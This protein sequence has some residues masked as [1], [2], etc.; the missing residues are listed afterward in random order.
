LGRPQRFRQSSPKVQQNPARRTGGLA[1]L[2][3]PTRRAPADLLR[4]PSARVDDV[5]T[6]AGHRLVQPSSRIPLLTIG[7]KGPNKRTGSDLLVRAGHTQGR[8]EA[9]PSRSLPSKPASHLHA[10]ANSD[11]SA[12]PWGAT[13]NTLTA[14]GAITKPQLLRQPGTFPNTLR[15]NHHETTGRRCNR[16]NTKITRERG[17]TSP[18]SP[19]RHV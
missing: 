19:T 2:R 18:P 4:I 9:L 16:H 14:V 13:P 6:S 10:E 7:E 8:Y 1:L 5:I 17:G 3:P 11:Q 12:R 15:Q